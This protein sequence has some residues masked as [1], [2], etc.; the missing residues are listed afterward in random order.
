[1]KSIEVV[2]GIIVCNGRVLCMQRGE[3]KF[4]YVSRKFEF[5]GGKVEAGESNSEALARELKEEMDIDVE[6]REDD[7]FMTVKHDYPDFS[8]TMHSYICKVSD[9]TFTM[10]EHSDFRW[11]GKNE[12]MQLDWAPADV[13]I[14]VAL[15]DSEVLDGEC[16]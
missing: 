6:V 10:N 1:M 16:I 5:P 8:I 4:E 2:A 14:V 3:S 11:L 12:L 7:Y 9:C 15:E 13:P